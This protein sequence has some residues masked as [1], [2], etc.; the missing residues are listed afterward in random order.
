MS[1]RGW[2]WIGLGC[3]AAFGAWSFTRSKPQPKPVKHVIVLSIDTQRVDRLSCYGYKH[4]LTPKI[5]S[6][7]AESVLFERCVSQASWTSP[8][9]VSMMSGCYVAEELMQIPPDKETLAECFQKAGWGTGA[10][11]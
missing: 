4:S 11:V 6:L 8:S 9:M 1:P 2:I 5:D 10:F 3:L 7:A